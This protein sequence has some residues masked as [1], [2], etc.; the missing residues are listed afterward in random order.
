MNVGYF[1]TYHFECEPGTV[2][3]DDLDQCVFPFLTGPPCGTAGNKQPE[4]TS[5]PAPNNIISEP[6]TTVT[7]T[8][9]DT[10]TTT[11]QTRPTSTTTEPTTSPSTT[12]IFPIDTTPQPT[13]TTESDSFTCFFNP[14]DC[15][16]HGPCSPDTVTRTLCTGCYIGETFVDSSALCGG[17]LGLLYDRD[18]NICIPDPAKNPNCFQEEITTLATT[19]APPPTT[20]TEPPPT[21]TTEL[22]TVEVTTQFS[23]SCS[24][25]NI[26]PKESWILNRYCHSFYLCTLDGLYTGSVRLCDNYYQCVLDNNSE[27]K[28]ELM[29]CANGQLFSYDQDKC[30]NKPA[31]SVGFLFLSAAFLSHLRRVICL[32]NHKF[33]TYWKLFEILTRSETDEELCPFKIRA[34]TKPKK[35]KGR[36]AR[37]L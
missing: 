37:I 8:N 22:A 31:A 29:S 4:I 13:T 23:L 12:V 25:D 24:F 26:R 16:I 28:T 3:S 6:P 36:R 20:T 7:P 35:T 5:S 30:V 1:W 15:L 9:P 34:S 33:C 32:A 17:E 10:I 27:W 21:T 14:D 18:N 19:T 11:G 2:F